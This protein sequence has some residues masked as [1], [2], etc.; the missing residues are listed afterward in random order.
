M[1]VRYASIGG[2]TPTHKGRCAGLGAFDVFCLSGNR[3]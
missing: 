1:I 3:L 2:K